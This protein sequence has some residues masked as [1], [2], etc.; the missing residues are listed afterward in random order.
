MDPDSPAAAAAAV[1]QDPAGIIGPPSAY[2]HF[3][4]AIRTL[5]ARV[6]TLAFSFAFAVLLARLLSPSDRG[7]F[8]LFSSLIGLALVLG[9]IAVAKAIV[10]RVGQGHMPLQLAGGAATSLGLMSGAGVM[11]VLLPLTLAFR[12]STLPGLSPLAIALALLLV[13]PLLLREYWSGV[14]L[15]E[16]RSLAYVVTQAL[17]PL[18]GAIV[19]AI[20][21]AANIRTLDGAMG[22]WT[23]G[24]VGSVAV[25]VA[26]V[27][28]RASVVP[29]LRGGALRTLGGYG[30]RTYPAFLA[31]FLN[32]R[33]DQFIVRWL[34]T[35]AVLGAYAVAVSVGELLIR[36]PR[37]MLWAYSGA[38]GSSDRATSADYVARFS[39]W[40]LTTLAPA[41]ALLAVITPVAIPL[42]FGHAYADAVPAILLLL[43]G[44]LCYAPAA[45]IVEYFIVQRGR[46]G[47]AAM[48][49]GTSTVV[50]V[51]AN[52][53][54]TPRFGV[55]GASAASS[56][57]YATMLLIAV[58]VFGRDAGTS[59]VAPLAVS[60]D[61]V[62][63]VGRSI[64][65]L[66]HPS[67]PRDTGEGNP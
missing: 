24:I 37:I 11:V 49:A 4:L 34:S 45:I 57:S 21:L 15:V 26:L 61:D 28:S 50:N 44:M 64:L 17:Q 54:L 22:A 19:L 55:A 23:V 46:P 62:K 35:A 20:L 14:L 58:I 13:T 51:V 5:A 31:T 9:N 12:D 53:L 36:I 43:P 3:R 1:G 47:T 65:S 66:A 38:L 59:P 10:H 30:L 33:L 16:G 48:I 32:L 7:D 40:T 60:I 8:A 63:T 18:G 6:A 27:Q 52:L 25:A 39:R 29:S 42:V 41:A 56:V 2:S 67:I